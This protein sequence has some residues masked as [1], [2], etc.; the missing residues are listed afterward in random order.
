MW[1]HM[2]LKLAEA[3]GSVCKSKAHLIDI[4]SSR[5]VRDIQANF[6]YGTLNPPGSTATYTQHSSSIRIL[7]PSPCRHL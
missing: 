7:L 3:G 1:L 2:P 6:L 4:V 5:R